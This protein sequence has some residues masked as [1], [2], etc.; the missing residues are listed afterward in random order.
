MSSFLQHGAYNAVAETF[1]NGLLCANKHELN[2]HTARTRVRHVR[3]VML[4]TRLKFLRCTS[5]TDRAYRRRHLA[6]K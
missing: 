2:R 4:D 5:L 1:V 3:Y 6:S